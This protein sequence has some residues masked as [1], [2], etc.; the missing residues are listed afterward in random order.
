[1]KK[2]GMLAAAFA[3][4]AIGVMPASTTRAE[5]PLRI[6]V[7]PAIAAVDYF[8]FWIKEIQGHPAVKSGKVVVTVFDGKLDPLVQ[9]EQFETMITQKFDGIIFAPVDPD[10]GAAA[11]ERA[12]DA[13][14][15][16]VGSVAEANS[17]TYQYIGTGDVEGGQILGKAVCDALP[18]GG[19]I[20]MIEGGSGST[21]Q[22]KRHNG[23]AEELAKCPQVKILATKTADWSRAKAQGV[24]DNWL[25][26]FPGQI[27]LVLSQNDDMSMGALASI[28]A[29]GIDPTTMPIYSIDGTKEAIQAVAEGRLKMTLFKDVHAEGEGAMDLILQKIIGADYKPES[30]VW[31]KLPWGDGNAKFVRVPW[32]VVTKDT[33]KDFMN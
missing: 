23:T 27:N 17:E 18:N 25:L 15:P 2:S 24:M 1:M 21:P 30:D 8:A 31:Q 32:G 9:T 7:V 3:A 5:E 12:I 20:V 22:T 19:N 4:L 16:V 13:K 28:E 6:G 14:I 11:I 10:A 29:A 26:A 33:A